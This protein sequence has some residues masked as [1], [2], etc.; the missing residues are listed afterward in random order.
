[1][2]AAHDDLVHGDRAKAIKDLEMAR[3]ALES[4]GRLHG[5]SREAL[6]LAD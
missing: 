1:M 2:K 5:G 6:S 4:C 3:A